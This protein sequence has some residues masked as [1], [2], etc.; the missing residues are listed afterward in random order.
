[1]KKVIAYDLGAQVATENLAWDET[2]EVILTKTENEFGDPIYNFKYPAYWKYSGMNAAS[3]NLMFRK[4]I[5]T[6]S[7]GRI[8]SNVDYIEP[9]DELIEESTNIKY[10]AIKNNI[11]QLFLIDIGGSVGSL[12]VN[13]VMKIVRSGHRNLQ[14]DNIG[15]ITSVFNPID[16][17]NDGI[18]NT[19]DFNSPL[20]GSNGILQASALQKSEDWQTKCFEP[21]FELNCA[22]TQFGNLV[23]YYLNGQLETIDNLESIL[24]V[25]IDLKL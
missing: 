18:H 4:T 7:N 2:G 3:K 24:L 20:A 1:M 9:G 6:N 17:N 8:T 22:L 12:I 14:K 15:T 19:L 25:L 10:W 16:H 5:S 21:E 11:N 13:K 23:I